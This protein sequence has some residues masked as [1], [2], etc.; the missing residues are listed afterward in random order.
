MSDFVSLAPSYMDKYCAR[1]ASGNVVCFGGFQSG[2]PPAIS[3]PRSYASSIL[4]PV[5]VDDLA[6]VDGV[7]CGTSTNSTLP[8]KTLEFALQQHPMLLDFRLGSG[9]PGPVSMRYH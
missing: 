7:F 2:D 1:R 5:F 6:G 3:L 4:E 9:T 8:C